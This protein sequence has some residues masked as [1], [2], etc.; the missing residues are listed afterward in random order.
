MEI[1][2]FELAENMSKALEIAAKFKFKVEIQDSRILIIHDDYFDGW[3]EGF[4]DIH[5]FYAFLK[6]FQLGKE[7]K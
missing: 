1:D 5:S 6:G 3:S 2:Q 7:S 4:Y